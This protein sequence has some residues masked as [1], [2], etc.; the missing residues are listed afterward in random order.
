MT[1]LD[2]IEKLNRWV[3][4]I[5]KSVLAFTGIEALIVLIIGV[6]SSN[7]YHDKYS[8]FWITIL[9]LLGFVY[10][11]FTI[12]KISYNSKFPSS[13]VEE[14]KSKRELE[15]SK[16]S[17]DRKDAINNYI[18]NTIIA[19][20]DCKCNIPDLK[21]NDD[22]KLES[23]KDFQTGL[24][25]LT[26][27]FNSVLNVLLNTSNIKFTTG[28]YAID[29]RGVN[30]KNAPEYNEG[31]FLL[32]DDYEISKI[33]NVKTLM[34]NSSSLGIELE[35]QNALKVSFNNG[36]YLAKEIEVREDKKIKIICSNI[37]NLKEYNQQKGVLFILTDN[38][39]AL[40]EDI[41][42]VLTMFSNVIS[43]WMD[44]YKHEVVSRQIDNLTASIENDDD[45]DDDDD[46]T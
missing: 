1:Y 22:W 35:I 37:K 19:L 14:L 21:E 18:S 33:D 32:R 23:D 34:T 4:V 3:K 26:T 36:K 38:I 6:A 41:E 5:Q 44:L 7:V 25:H 2:T 12:I 17:I 24:K 31:T 9:V 11:L 30:H 16:K 15:I 29:I 13:I 42:S 8:N 45:D 10:V 40:P 43:H 39:N 46:K 20:S 28:V 27:T